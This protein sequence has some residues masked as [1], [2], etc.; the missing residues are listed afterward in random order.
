MKKK[1]LLKQIR[2]LEKKVNRLEAG[3]EIK[4]IGFHYL[5]DPQDENEY[6]D[7]GY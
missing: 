3:P 4:Q 7:E 2:K 5:T 1:K 6:D